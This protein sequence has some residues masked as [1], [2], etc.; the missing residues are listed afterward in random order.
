MTATTEGVFSEA[1]WVLFLPASLSSE[2]WL[3]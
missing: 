3:G 2:R 1:P